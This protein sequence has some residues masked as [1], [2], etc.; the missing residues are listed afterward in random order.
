MKKVTTSVKI[1]AHRAAYYLGQGLALVPQHPFR[2]PGSPGPIVARKRQ[3]LTLRDRDADQ[4]GNAA[5]TACP[6]AWLWKN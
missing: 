2:G 1:I 6:D 4:A 3:Y 5:G